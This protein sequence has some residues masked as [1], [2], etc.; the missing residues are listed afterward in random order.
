MGTWPARSRGFMGGVLQG[1]S[2]IGFMISS[3]MCGLFYS[4]IGWRGVLWIGVLPA[5]AVLYVRKYVKEPAVWIENRRLQRIEQREV[6]A[7]LSAI[8]KPV[9][10]VNTLTACWWM[11]SGF[12]CYYSIDA[13]FATHLQKDSALSSG[14][15]G[16][17][18]L[19][20]LVLSAI[21]IAPLYLMTHNLLWIAVGFV[22]QGMCGGGMQGQ[23]APYLNE[24]FPTEVRVTAAAFCYHQGAIWGGLVPLVLTY[25]AV[26]HNLG[27]A[28]P[29]LIATCL[30]ALSFALSLVYPPRPGA[31]CW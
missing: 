31:R 17:A 21:P 28:V 6:R 2:G 1:S 16:D 12:I 29:M 13:L 7:P 22:L 10:L 25:F 8:I 30:A 23:M 19:I 24:R 18:D 9:V 15:R 11:A 5:L 4:Y 27:F 26:H 3:A 14:A 20:I